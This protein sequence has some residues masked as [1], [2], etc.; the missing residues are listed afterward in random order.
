MRVNNSN[1]HFWNLTH[2]G[3]AA[4]K[5]GHNSIGRE[6]NEIFDKPGDKIV[7]IWSEASKMTN[8][9]EERK[10]RAQ[11]LLYK[12]EKLLPVLLRVNRLFVFVVLKK[13][14]NF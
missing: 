4:T 2:E 12:L 8:Q 7:Q 6:I 10:S 1:G 5:L 13:F 3:C 14:I 11:L 9:S